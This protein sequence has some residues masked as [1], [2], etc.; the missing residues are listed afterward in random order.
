M[1]DVQDSYQEAIIFA[2]LKHLKKNQKVKGTELPYVVHLSNVAM[3]IIMAASHTPK[4]DLD[5][6]VQVALLH[7]V[8]EDTSTPYDDLHENFGTDIATAVWSLSK[9]KDLPK[10]EQIL[11]SI[12]KIKLLDKEVWAV[13]LADRITN[14]QPPPKNWN[15]EKRKEYQKEARVILA[16]LKGGNIYLEKRLRHKIK[17]YSDYINGYQYIKGSCKNCGYET[18]ELSIG[19]GFSNYMTFYGF[20]VLDK[21]K[22]VIKIKNI[23]EKKRIN[24]LYPNYVFYNHKSLIDKPSKNRNTII[25]VDD[26][27]LYQDG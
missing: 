11:D 1:F 5:F 27:K 16:E 26:Y 4:F 8:L 6:A 24:K 3:E 20:P 10:N 14:L 13:K 17:E 2:T 19:S 15:R 9:N 18:E 22:K 25:E 23:F 12:G 7:D 21:L